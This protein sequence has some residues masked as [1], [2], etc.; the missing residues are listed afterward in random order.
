MALAV[1]RGDRIVRRD[2]LM[3]NPVVNIGWPSAS[4]MLAPICPFPGP[5]S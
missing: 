3:N 5:A 4:A 2:T 1:F